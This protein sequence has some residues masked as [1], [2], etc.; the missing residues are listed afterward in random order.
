MYMCAIIY[1]LI[2]KKKKETDICTNL[3]SDINVGFFFFFPFYPNEI[4]K[5]NHGLKEEAFGRMG[6]GFQTKTGPKESD[7]AQEIPFRPKL[8]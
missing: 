5:R 2:W 7:W 3:F 4:Q 6:T 8:W 1:F